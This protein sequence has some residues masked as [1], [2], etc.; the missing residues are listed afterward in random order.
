MTFIYIPLLSYIDKSFLTSDPYKNFTG[1]RTGYK[2]MINKMF[3]VKNIITIEL[4]IFL[5][6]TIY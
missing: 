4:L 1:P 2:K 5:I 3:I 6:F